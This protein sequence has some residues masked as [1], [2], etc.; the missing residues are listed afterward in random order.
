MTR[1]KIT[2]AQMLINRSNNGSNTTETAARIET[3]WIALTAT[4]AS[5]VQGTI[6]F[7]VAFTSVPIV[8]ATYGGDTAGASS[9]LGSGA[10]NV[11]QAYADA[12][13]LTTSGFTALA[14]TRDAT[15]WTAGN[16]IYIQWIAIGT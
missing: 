3:G 5:T 8:T 9:T 13:A 10:I 11:K 16:T 15:N 12:V 4:A 14:A 6:T 2:P 7:P 1:T